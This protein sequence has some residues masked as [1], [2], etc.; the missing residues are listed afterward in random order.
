LER[1]HIILGRALQC[2]CSKWTGTTIYFL[3]SFGLYISLY[4]E[5]PGWL[6]F[7]SNT[8]YVPM[9]ARFGALLLESQEMTSPRA[10]VSRDSSLGPVDADVARDKSSFV[11][12]LDS[13]G[14]SSLL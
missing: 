8:R 11:L 13:T 6:V 9:Q 3:P 5:N 7:S 10:L 2:P 12:P 1:E 14:T 4:M